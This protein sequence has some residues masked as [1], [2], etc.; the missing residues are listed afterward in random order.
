MRIM[1][2]VVIMKFARQMHAKFKGKTISKD[3]ATQLETISTLKAF[4]EAHLTSQNKLLKFLGDSKSVNGQAKFDEC[5]EA[6][7]ILESWT[8][9]YQAIV[10]GA[11]EIEKVEVDAPW[12]IGGMAVLRE[13]YRITEEFTEFV[14][15][16][17]KA[18]I[19]KEREAE[20]I[21]HPMQDQMKRAG[22]IFADCHS[23]IHRNKLKQAHDMSCQPRSSGSSPSRDG[24][25]GE[26]SSTEI[27]E[28]SEEN[29]SSDPVW[30]GFEDSQPVNEGS[31]DDSYV[32]VE[33][34]IEDS[35]PLN[36]G[37]IDEPPVRTD[38]VSLDV[39]EDTTCW[40]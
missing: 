13:S 24:A 3:L 29:P 22:S 26:S 31:I 17:A 18:G 28:A 14:V 40:M 1:R 35:M 8:Q 32:A 25:S 33:G 34:S 4:V 23:G 9:V 10:L 27:Q 38:A 15:S 30:E 11:A 2:L 37:S 6:R 36:E 5:E 19:L 16:A 39:K 20:C 12:I 21:I 7:C